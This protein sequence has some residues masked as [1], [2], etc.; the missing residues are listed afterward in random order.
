MANANNENITQN[1]HRH[2]TA[3]NAL[4]VHLPQQFVFHQQQKKFKHANERAKVAH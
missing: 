3:I 2:N 4:N 1:D